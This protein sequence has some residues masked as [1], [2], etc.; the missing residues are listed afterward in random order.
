[1][2]FC[3]LAIEAR[4]NHLIDKLL[5]DNRISRAESVAAQRIAPEQKWFLLPKLAGRRRRLP[6]NA[7]PH[8]AVKEI[9]TRRNALVHVD[10]GKLSE[11]LPAPRKMLSLFRGFVQAMED[12]NVLMRDTRG[13]RKRVTRLAEFKCG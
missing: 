11:Q 10:F 13:P 3:T 5:D 9:C 2:A 1:M 8:Q 4:A 12:M 7:G 6:D